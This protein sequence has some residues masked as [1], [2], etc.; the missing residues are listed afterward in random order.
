[1]SQL[2]ISGI[3]IEI[4]D[5]L[6]KYIHR[7][8]EGLEKYLSKH[9]AESLKV[10]VRLAEGKP[11]GKKVATCKIRVSLPNDSFVVKEST[12]NLYAA[13]DIAEE[14]LRHAYQKYT[15]THDRARFYRRII[16]RFQ[17]HP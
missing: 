8:L 6:R 5:K 16:G 13:V 9:A 11:K 14:K 17:R 15:E 12:V 3:H 10:E 7:K 1:M 4:D 2:T